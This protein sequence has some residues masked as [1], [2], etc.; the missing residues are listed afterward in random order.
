MV[1]KLDESIIFRVTRPMAEFLGRWRFDDKKYLLL[2]LALGGTYPFKV[3]GIHSPY[4]GIPAATVEMI[5]IGKTRY[6]VDWV[7]VT[8]RIDPA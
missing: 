4:Q 1:F 3:N 7:K 6:M 2:N 8:Q 5:K